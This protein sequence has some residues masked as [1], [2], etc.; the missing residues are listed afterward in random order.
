MPTPFTASEAIRVLKIRGKVSNAT[1][2][3]DSDILTLLN[4]SYQQFVVGFT[5]SLR[6]EWW[7]GV[8]PLF[9]T[10]DSDSTIVIPSSVANS[11]RTIAWDQGGQVYNPLNRIEPEDQFQYLSQGNTGTPYGFMF[12][13]NQITILPKCPGISIRLTYMYTPPQMVLEQNAGKVTNISGSVFTLSSVPLEWQANAP[14]S[15][16]VISATDPYTV[17][18]VLPVSSLNVSTKTITLSTVPTTLSHWNELSANGVWVANVGESPFPQL[19]IALQDLLQQHCLE[20]IMQ[21]SADPR[22][23]AITDRKKELITEL[24]AMMSPRAQGSSRPLVNKNKAG[25]G[26]YWGRN[27][28]AKSG[29]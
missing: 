16:N 14:T 22:L 26:G 18:G 6:D 9:L 20:T 7:V 24:K 17:I 15:I 10:T 29:R 28:W 12:N 5:Q 27:L 23:K 13:D 1:S 25:Y 4:S 2:L 8:K 11:V 3:N 21:S 19:P